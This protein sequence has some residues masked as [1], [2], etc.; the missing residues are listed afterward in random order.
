MKFNINRFK[1]YFKK[2]TYADKIYLEGKYRKL[3]GSG[4]NEKVEA[5]KRN[6]K[7]KFLAATALFVVFMTFS[8]ISYLSSGS[9]DNLVIKN[10]K[11]N[12]IRP[13]EGEDTKYL[14]MKMT[15]DTGHGKIIKHLNIAVD[16]TTDEKGTDNSEKNKS[17]SKG[18]VL[19]KEIQDAVY[20]L[21]DNTEA[22]SMQLPDR[23]AGGEKIIWEDDRSS[24]IPII[25]AGFILII[26]C[27]YKNRFSRLKN[28]E[29]AAYESVIRELPEFINK[30]ILLL[31]AGVV[32][33]T[34]F[35]TIMEDR[36]KINAD[37]DNYFYGQMHNIFMKVS[38]ANGSVHEEL[39]SFSKRSGVRELMRV[40]NIICD[41]VEKGSDLVGKLQMESEILWHAR[42]KQ[43][44]ERGK[45]AETKMT[46]P[47]AVLLIILVLITIA[48]AM[49]EM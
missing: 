8:I 41:N 4:G 22:G 23:L 5:Y 7:N 39:R 44:E 2:I 29:K 17:I 28:D 31:N 37:K 18:E 14:D 33:Y 6:L 3:Y 27:I 47:L 26:V 45:T 10:G 21:N 35:I 43:S 16:P 49:I 38:H 9:N 12:V 20:S 25:V 19:E 32:I 30:I 13:A 11:A 34:A 15:V 46:F 1:E 36:Q 40:S 48:P 24:G 42:K